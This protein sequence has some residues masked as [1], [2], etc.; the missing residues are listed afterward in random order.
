MDRVAH[1]PRID[2]APLF[3]PGASG[4][5]AVDA[6]VARAAREAGFLTVTGLPD[7]VPLG[8]PARAALLR[9][10]DLPPASKRRL[11]RKASAPENPNVY[12]GY[13]PLESG[14][15]KEGMDVGPEHAGGGEP[16]D[17]LAEPTP[18]PDEA[19]LPGWRDDARR[20]YAGLESVGRALMGSLARGLGLDERV[21]DEPFRGGNSTL[22]LLAYP[23]W[24]PIAAKHGLALR[25]LDA[26]GG[27]RR[28][29]IGGEHV[30][31][32]FVTLLQQDEVGGLQA[33][34]AGD[35]W[36]DVP[37]VESALVVNFGKL[38]E[39]WTGGRIRATEHR[40][41]GN[42]RERRS[43]PFFFEPRID[44]RIA[45]LPLEGAEDFEPF[46]YGDHLW[47]AMT[48]FVEFQQATRWPDDAQSP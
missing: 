15:I 30:D 44:A 33:R 20:A 11:W 28:Y 35:A 34:L 47:D 18:W 29:D 10:F 6:A 42:D 2:V 31:S 7:T 27:V 38:L 4:R 8:A 16:G 46:T 12:R 45:S 48:K 39:R 1:V 14:V 23:P 13:F 22:R 24:P 36:V 5:D 3:A 40:V 9:L 32:G 26:P 17:A 41:L 37:P 43:I 25:P 21:F 19:A